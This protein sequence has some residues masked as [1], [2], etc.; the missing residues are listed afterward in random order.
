MLS[1]HLGIDLNSTPV[2]DAFAQEGIEEIGEA[3]EAGVPITSEIEDE[4]EDGETQSEEKEAGSE[5][6]VTDRALSGKPTN[7]K[8]LMYLV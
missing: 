7:P 5:G 2:E 8:K 4:S 1:D 3:E 6:F